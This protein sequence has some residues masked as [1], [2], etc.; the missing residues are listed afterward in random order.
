VQNNGDSPVTRKALSVEQL[1]DNNAILNILLEEAE[2]PE[3]SIHPCIKRWKEEMSSPTGLSIVPAAARNGGSG[4]DPDDPDDPLS[5]VAQVQGA[6]YPTTHAEMEERMQREHRASMISLCLIIV[7][8]S[9]A[10]V[11]LP[12]YLVVVV[13][14]VGSCLYAR[15][16]YHASRPHH[17]RQSHSGYHR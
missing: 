9:F 10:M 2:K 3:E 8:I 1:Y 7:I 5:A 14:A 12:F 6:H 4:S 13:L 17:R 15:R 16:R 11:Y